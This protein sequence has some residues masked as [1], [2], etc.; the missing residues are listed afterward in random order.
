MYIYVPC[1]VNQRPRTSRTQTYE[2]NKNSGR[3][4]CL[5]KQTLVIEKGRRLL[6]VFGCGRQGVNVGLFEC[7]GKKRG[8]WILK[9]I[10]E[11]APSFI[12]MIQALFPLKL[13]WKVH[14]TCT[15]PKKNCM[16]GHILYKY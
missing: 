14:C 13:S 2:I 5:N 10:H 3:S 4:S 6:V 11:T 1:E 15:R 8:I 12:I 16:I 7:L 9:I